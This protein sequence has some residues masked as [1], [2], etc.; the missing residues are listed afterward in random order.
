M[1][2]LRSSA[3]VV[4]VVCWLLPA[5][6][7]QENHHDHDPLEPVNRKIFWFN[8]Q[9]DVYVLEPIAKG[10]DAITPEPVQRLLANFFANLDLPLAFVNDLLQGKVRAGASDVGRFAVNS[11]VGVLGFFDP[12]SSWGL[13]QH[14]EDFGQTFGRWGIPPGPYLV[15]P[16][17]GPSNPRDALGRIGDSAARVYPFF[18][19]QSASISTTAAE[20]IN[21]RAR[22]LDEVREA[23][24]SAL[25]YYTFVRNAYIQHREA[26]V[27]DGPEISRETDEDLYEIRDEN[28]E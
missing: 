25:D 22:A 16:F 2:L 28:A 7:A 1:T 9:V 11:T 8:D 19:P 14:I 13:E 15:L 24:A 5:C 3:V 27:N 26:L 20:L 4:W 17:L 23:K 18:A 12:A 10:W 6:F 21:A